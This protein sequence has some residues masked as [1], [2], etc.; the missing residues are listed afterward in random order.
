[1]ESNP[2][3]GSYEKGAWTDERVANVRGGDNA[4]HRGGVFDAN[5]FAAGWSGLAS[6]INV[7]AF[8]MAQAAESLRRCSPLWPKHPRSEQFDRPELPVE[9]CPNE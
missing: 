4:L 3:F 2:Y 6:M 7:G 1:M 8:H 9:C 5:A